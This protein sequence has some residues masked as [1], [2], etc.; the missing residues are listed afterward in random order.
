MKL[1]HP[2]LLK[3][4]FYQSQ[5]LSNGR[6]ARKCESG[7]RRPNFIVPENM[8]DI[9]ASNAIGRSAEALNRCLYLQII[10]VRVK[11]DRFFG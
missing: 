3:I 10:E 6:T 8:T 2:A 7:Q 5:L 11:E 1:T 9:A 4:T